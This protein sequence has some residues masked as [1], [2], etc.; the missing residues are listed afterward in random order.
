MIAGRLQ[1]RTSDDIEVRALSG[2][3]WRVMDRRI[4]RSNALC[5]VGFIAKNHDHF[6]VLEFL[7]PVQRRVY[8]SMR[9]A[10]SSFVNTPSG[11]PDVSG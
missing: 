7:D 6:E 4:A 10:T 1:T 2:C 11:S 3:E 5:L 8:P 9:E